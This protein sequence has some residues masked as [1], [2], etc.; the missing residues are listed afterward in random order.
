MAG[1]RHPP[2]RLVFFSPMKAVAVASG[3]V[4]QRKPLSI[5]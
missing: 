5:E 4:L 3:H 2:S 1:R